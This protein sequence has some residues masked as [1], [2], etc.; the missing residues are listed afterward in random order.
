MPF[1]TLINPMKIKLTWLSKPYS[2]EP[3]KPLQIKERD[4]LLANKENLVKKTPLESA[5]LMINLQG[6]VYL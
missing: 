5:A 4:Q 1:S 6:E 2:K 3:A